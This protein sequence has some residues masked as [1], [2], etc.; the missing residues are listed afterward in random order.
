M[1]AKATK[2]PLD[3]VVVVLQFAVEPLDPPQFEML[4][5]SLAPSAGV[6]P[7]CVETRVVT[8]TQVLVVEESVVTQV[9]RSKISE[10]PDG[11]GAVAP[12]FVASEV[13]ETKSPELLMEGLELAPF[14]AVEVSGDETKN[15][16]GMQVLVEVAVDMLQVSRM[17]TCGMV[18]S[19]AVMLE[20]RLVASETKATNS[21]S[22][23][24]T[25][26]KLGPLPAD[27]PSAAMEIN[28]GTEVLALVPV[29]EVVEEAT[30]MGRQ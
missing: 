24:M 11:L 19:P 16:V 6:V 21:P 12:K 27:W 13:K 26:S 29:Q 17:K 7:S 23:L 30:Q 28:C 8:G 15:V 2:R 18:P 1:E 25:G 22:G 5:W 10:A 20:T 14:P 9:E 4:D 3:A